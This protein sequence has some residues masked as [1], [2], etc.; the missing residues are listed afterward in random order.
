[1]DRPVQTFDRQAHRGIDT[2]PRGPA[3]VAT[4]L[5]VD[6]SASEVKITAAAEDSAG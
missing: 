3:F 4:G 5:G 1:M 2:S 6:S